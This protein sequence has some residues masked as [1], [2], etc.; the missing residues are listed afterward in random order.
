[1]LSTAIA[2]EKSSSNVIINGSFEDVD[3]EGIPVK[4]TWRQ[5][6]HVHTNTDASKQL[7]KKWQDRVAVLTIAE[8]ATDGKRCALFYT[9]EEIN[10]DREDKEQG[11]PM[12][13]NGLGTTIAI[14]VSDQT[15]NYQLNFML[16]GKLAKVPGLNKFVVVIYFKG[17]DD[18]IW[19]CKKTGKNVVKHFAMTDSWKKQNLII[20]VPPKTNYLEL[21]LK[22]Y[23][24][25]EAMV[26]DVKLQKQ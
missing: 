18:K 26:D 1:M 9:P 23:G 3:A 13:S 19:R 22:L 25:G 11:K 15:T 5:S 4:G 2:G 6:W 16:R 24:C 20:S 7:K 12:I 8:N 17:G 10:E 14:P 21:Y